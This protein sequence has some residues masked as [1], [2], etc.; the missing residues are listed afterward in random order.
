MAER[1]DLAR[2]AIRPQDPFAQFGW[3]SVDAVQLAL[4]VSVWLRHDV[5]PTLMWNF[6]TIEALAI[7]LA[8]LV[9]DAPVSSAAV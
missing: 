4:D 1:L 7:H 6:P 8:P 9:L 5:D 3:D 2:D